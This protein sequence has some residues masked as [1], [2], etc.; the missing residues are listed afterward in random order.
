MIHTRK[1]KAKGLIDQ[2]KPAF[3]VIVTLPVPAIVE[4]AGHAGADFVFIDMEHGAI[5]LQTLEAMI[6]AANVVD[7]APIVRV[8]ENNPKLILRILDV[9]AQGIIVP[10]V[11]HKEDAAKAADAIKYLPLGNRGMAAGC[12]AAGYGTVPA[13][14]HIK[15]SNEEVL[16]IP[17]I[18]DKEAVNDIEGVLSVEG[19]DA[20]IIGPRDLAASLGVPGT[21]NHPSVVNAIEKVAEAT[22]KSGKIL[23]LPGFHGIYDPGLPK[24]I[25]LGTR[26]ILL[27]PG[28]TGLLLRGYHG[29]LERAKEFR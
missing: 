7:I 29:L 28:D 10:D 5:D 14:R 11:K 23:G 12:R 4:L 18:E 13:L 25:E 24:L 8:P 6:M 3:G 17:L 19:I 27:A 26:L 1:N 9:G 16:A 21:R 20:V 15:E 2:G 22:R